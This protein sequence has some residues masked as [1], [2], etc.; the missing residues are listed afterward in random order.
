MQRFPALFLDVHQIYNSYP[1]GWRKLLNNTIRE[2]AANTNQVNI[3]LNKWV[4]TS[5]VT[6]KQ[7]VCVL[8]NDFKDRDINELLIAKHPEL[9]L[10]DITSNPFVTIRKNIK[11]VKVRNLQYKMLHNIYPTM[12]HL[13]RWKIKDTDDCGLCNVQETLKHASYDCLVARDAITQL[14]N[15]IKDRYS[16]IENNLTLSYENVTVGTQSSRVNFKLL[17]IQKVAVDMILIDL[18]QRLILQRET[19][20]WLTRSDINNMFENRKRIE[21]YN[22]A[23]YRNRTGI[24]LDSK[25][26]NTLLV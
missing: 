24:D 3:G 8:N 4:D 6:L 25:W 1:Q 2:H 10:A 7:L 9:A 11:D 16:C 15:V 5:N 12:K 22:K 26:G 21:K 20:L 19:K 13:K 23:K 18:K 14:E 17:R